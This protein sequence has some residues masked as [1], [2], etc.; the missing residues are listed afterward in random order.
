[1]SYPS[2]LSNE[3]FFEIEKHLPTKAKTKPRK[4]SY[5]E[6]FNGIM[7]VLV[8]GC[9]W[10]MLPIDLPPWSIVYHYFNVWKKQGVITLALKK[11]GKKVSPTF[12]HHNPTFKRYYR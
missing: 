11:S 12:L 5:H 2:D 6:I 1:M 8:S 9:Q 3:Q 4:W 10:R 7:Y